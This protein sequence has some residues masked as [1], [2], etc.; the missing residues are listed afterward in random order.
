M[1]PR[2]S[3]RQRRAKA[4]WNPWRFAHGAALSRMRPIR[5]LAATPIVAKPVL[6]PPTNMLSYWEQQHFLLYDHIVIGAGI[7][8]L[9]TAL[10]LKARF[11]RQRVLVLERGLLPTGATTRNAGFACM[12]SATEILDD[13]PHS[14]PDAVAALFLKRK[15]GLDLLRTRLRDEAL[16]YRADGGYELLDEAGLPALERLD[17]LN[18]LLRP[19]LGKDA[20]RP[21]PE[22]IAAFGFATDRVK[23]LI[24]NTCEGSIDSGKAVRSLL[25]L[26]LQAGIEVKTGAAVS[27]FAEEEGRVA[28]LV[29][30][31]FRADEL[32]LACERLFICTNAFTRQ[33]L[34]DEEVVPG[35]GQ[36]LVTEVVPGLPFRGVFHYDRGYYYF[37]EIDGRVLF[38]GGRNL[39]FEGETSTDFH[40]NET[41]QADLEEKLRH[42]I[43]PGREVRIAMRWSGIMAFG[44]VK[45]PVVRAFSARVYGAFRMGGMGV[46]L[47]S[48]AAADLV[49]L[50]S[51]ARLP[52]APPLGE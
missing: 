24:E 13:L 12:G 14:S 38:G 35:R 47:G 5:Q 8:G 31:P 39:D 46:A 51:P 29:R 22:K 45:G 4:G 41:I 36:V 7:V 18:A 49:D 10:E 15:Q 21:V 23:G 52:P 44:P 26:C 17:E 25:D 40:L 34:P 3:A 37:R 33:L 30:D 42:M 9:S 32:P 20:Y 19:L 48:K 43:L 1:V 6:N 2:Y 28:V 27:R 50:L 11:P 16:G